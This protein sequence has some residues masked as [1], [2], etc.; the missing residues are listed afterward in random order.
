MNNY[1]RFDWAIKRILR[2]K[3]NQ[4]VLE[5]FLSV[6]LKDDIRIERFL[7]S[8]GNQEDES[9]KF[10]R[11]DI[12]AETS[13][14]EL[15]IIEVQNCH[16]LDYFH[17][18]LYGTAKAVTDYINIGDVYGKIRKV[19][20]INIVY[21]ELGQGLDYVYHGKTKFVGLHEPHDTLKLTPKQR[22][23]FLG[24]QPAGTLTDSEVGDI[25]PEYYVLRVNDFDK[26]AKTPLDEWINF[27]KTSDIKSTD[28]APGLK[29][30]RE[31]L[32]VAHLSPK[33]R[34]VY[35]RRMEN[36]RYQKSILLSNY[37]DGFLDGEKKGMEKGIQEGM[38]K[39]IQKGREK[40]MQEG[41]EKGIQEGEINER[42]KNARKLKSLGVSPEI[43]RQATGLSLEEIEK[44]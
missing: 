21:F 11:V 16:E 13:R 29:E 31:K 10:N 8:E 28:T 9:D 41:M 14:K 43:I 44:L 36:M 12:L 17:R 34:L 15:V 33:E 35:N 5:G 20:S 1:I 6:L 23:N 40:G 26:V 25:F 42:L 22:T 27:L 2:D 18:M 4:V 19:Y 37:Q 32:L 3:A 7:E 39:G 38:E 24:E 30:A